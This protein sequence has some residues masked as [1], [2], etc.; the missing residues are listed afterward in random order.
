MPR[1][2]AVEVHARGYGESCRILRDATALRRGV[3]RLLLSQSRRIL[4]RCHG[5]RP[6]HPKSLPKLYVA[7]GGVFRPLRLSLPARFRLLY[8]SQNQIMMVATSVR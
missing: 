4:R 6:W 8:T 2:C 7:D 3:S 1:P 5:A